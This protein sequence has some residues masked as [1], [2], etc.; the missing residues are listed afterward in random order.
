MVR[1]GNEFRSRLWLYNSFLNL[2]LINVN[3]VDLF[4]LGGFVSA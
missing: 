2:S 3:F 4:E 1:T